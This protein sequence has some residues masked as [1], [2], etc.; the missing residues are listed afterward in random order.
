[1]SQHQN[2]S[3]CGQPALASAL[4]LGFFI[5][6]IQIIQIIYFSHFL[7]FLSVL[8]LLSAHL[9]AAILRLRFKSYSA[10]NPYNTETGDRLVSKTY[11]VSA[12]Q[13]GRKHIIVQI[14]M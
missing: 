10:K 2:L 8:F 6:I 12:G 4:Q 9:L 13:T 7:L 3:R 1:M 14:I 11:E 5:G